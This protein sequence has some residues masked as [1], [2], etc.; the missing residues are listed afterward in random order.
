[1]SSIK[2]SY[3]GCFESDIMAMSKE[4][5]QKAVIR[6]FSVD[7]TPFAEGDSWNGDFLLPDD[8]ADAFRGRYYPR[9]TLNDLG[10]A[11]NL[12]IFNEGLY[13]FRGNPVGR[14]CILANDLDECRDLYIEKY[15]LD[16]GKRDPA[17]LKMFDDAID[18]KEF[19]V[20]EYLNKETPRIL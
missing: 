12:Y 13:D 3:S 15:V 18:K 11:M 9:Y 6:M 16:Y 2:T 10:I 8:L 5:L 17:S 7:F 4:E 1:M 20:L 19:I 14:I